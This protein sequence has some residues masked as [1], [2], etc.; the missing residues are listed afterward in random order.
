MK[1]VKVLSPQVAAKIAAGEVVERPASVVKEL[2]ENALDANANQI[3]VETRGGGLE[4]MRLTDD[5]SGIESEDVE[6]AFERYATSK[7]N[8]VEDLH[9]IT[10]LGFRGEA[11]ACIAA[12]AQVDITTSIEEGTPFPNN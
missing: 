6:T 7:I 5:G 8:D 12:V 1:K 9:A 4:S 3:G 10:T 2:L 11:L